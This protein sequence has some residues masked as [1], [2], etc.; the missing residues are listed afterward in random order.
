MSLS[1]ATRARR[2]RSASEA[3][4]RAAAGGNSHGH[5]LEQRARPDW[6]DQPAVE[7]LKRRLPEGPPFE[8]RKQHEAAP[9]PRLARGLRQPIGRLG[10]K[11]AI[12]DDDIGLL[13][14]AQRLEAGIEAVGAVDADACFDQPRRDGR[15]L[16]RRIG[17][18]ERA[19]SLGSAP[20]RSDARRGS[21]AA[22][23][24]N[25]TAK[26]KID[27]PPGL[28]AS[29]SS[30]PMRRTSSREIESP[31][32]APSKRRACEPSPCSKLSKIAPRRSAGTPGPVSITE[33]RAAPLRRAR[34]S[35]RRR[36][37]R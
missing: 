13:R 31:S 36:R 24:G 20:L 28:S 12:D 1:S 19:R 3:R 10:A 7:T 17:D 18:D 30:P 34:P 21:T 6:L 25:W 14:T 15:R 23:S 2:T 11:R 35:R 5:A 37:C 16:E 9:D 26:E 8:R 27:P 29:V 22:H 4:R 32:P 33:N